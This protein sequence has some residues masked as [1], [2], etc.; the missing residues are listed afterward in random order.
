MW[1]TRDILIYFT[2]ISQRSPNSVHYYWPTAALYGEPLLASGYYSREEE[3]NVDHR[4]ASRTR[5]AG[6]KDGK[7]GRQYW[8]KQPA[9]GN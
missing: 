5:P 3:G 1:G 9:T 7:R 4:T 8:R 2:F 6:R